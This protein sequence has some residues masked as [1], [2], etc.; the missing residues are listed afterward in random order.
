MGVQRPA[1]SLPAAGAGARPRG[2]GRRGDRNATWAA[3]PHVAAVC[4]S[5][6][7][8]PRGRPLGRARRCEPVAGDR[9]GRRR[10]RRVR[11]PGLAPADHRGVRRRRGR[12]RGDAA[13]RLRAADARRRRLAPGRARHRRRRL[14]V[15]GH[16]GR[17]GPAAAP[18]TPRRR[19]WSDRPDGV[20]DAA[21]RRCP[22]LRHHWRPRPLL[23]A[24]L[25]TH[26][27]GPLAVGLRQCHPRAAGDRRAPG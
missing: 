25:A 23:A 12:G 19:R 9:V 18:A 4:R 14:V 11:C 20:A 2:A 13:A 8:R 26:G 3:G 17:S 15:G 21:P 1:R 7:V 16:G 6:V 27:D 22:A 24:R 10:H 5:R